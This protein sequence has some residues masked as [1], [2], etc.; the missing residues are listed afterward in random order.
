MKHEKAVCTRGNRADYLRDNGW[1]FWPA[2]GSF[3]KDGL[4][5]RFETNVAFAMATAGFAV[6]PVC[7]KQEGQ[8]T[9]R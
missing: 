7:G 6:C 4:H 1:R 5:G 3:T 2:E 9:D 8:E